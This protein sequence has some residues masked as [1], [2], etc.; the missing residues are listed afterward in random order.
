MISLLREAGV[1]VEEKSLVYSDFEQA[2]ELWSCGN[3][4]K[5]AP[6]TRIDGRTL[7]AGPLYRKA[8][9]LYWQFAHS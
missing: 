1:R 7:A 8:R 3:Y 6:I 4:A 9:E 5:V 2:D